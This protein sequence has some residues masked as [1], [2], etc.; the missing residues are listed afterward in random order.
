MII[1]LEKKSRNV[2]RYA[3]LESPRDVS[4]YAM[5]LSEMPKEEL[6]EIFTAGRPRET[7]SLEAVMKTAGGTQAPM[8]Q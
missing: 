3:G 2:V 8:L 4:N 1:V 6:S 7:H 5:I